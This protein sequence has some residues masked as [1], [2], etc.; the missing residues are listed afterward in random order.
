MGTMRASQILVWPTPT[1][2]VPTKSTA[3]KARHVLVWSTYCPFKCSLGAEFAKQVMGM[4]VCS[5]AS[6]K[7]RLQLFFLS[8]MAPE[9]QLWF[10]FHLCWWATHWGLFRR[11]PQST[12]E[13]GTEVA[14]ARVGGAAYQDRAC[15]VAGGCGYERINPNQHSS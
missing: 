9:A 5:S 6:C 11:L 8:C 13:E 1:C 7:E 2:Y 14:A 10:Q 4:S 12:P 15:G 3:A